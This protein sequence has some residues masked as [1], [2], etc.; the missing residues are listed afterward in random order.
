MGRPRTRSLPRLS[1]KRKQRL[2]GWLFLTP[3]IAYLLFAFALP[4]VYNVILSFQKTSPATIADLT[5]PFAGLAN[6][7]FVLRDPTSRTAIVHTL[8]F[9][10]G[11]LLGQFIIGFALALLFTLRFPGKT[12]A[13]SLIIVPWLLPLIVTGVIF[14]FLFQAEGGAVNQLLVAVGLSHHPVQ[15]LSDPHLAL[16][17]ILIANIWLG[18]PF[19]TLLL[20]GA[21]QDVPLEVKEAAIIDGAGPWQRLRR[22]IV[23]IILP[24]IEVAMLLGF[25]FTVKVFD[26]VFGLTG[27]GPANS[28]QL[29]TTWSYNL[30]FQEFSF[31]EGAALNNVLLALALICSPLYLWLSRDSLRRSSGAER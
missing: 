10:V 11:S 17:T 26:L 16:W 28:T 14:R 3:A 29:I 13:R 7:G 25:V 27:G 23:P 21:L 2:A 5:A 6:Y 12:F 19:F 1:G 4:I 31:S 24:V 15:W 18:V 8:E 9:T 22:V 30:S 20:Y